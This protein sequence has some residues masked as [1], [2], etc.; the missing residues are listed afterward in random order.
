MST[1]R[2]EAKLDSIQ[3]DIGQI[4][5]TLAAQHIEIKEH[6]RRTELLESRVEPIETQLTRL[7]GAFW[8]L[9]GLAALAGIINAVFHLMGH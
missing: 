1:D 5:A 3:K 4:N 8:A 9:S 7:G 6:I 2:I